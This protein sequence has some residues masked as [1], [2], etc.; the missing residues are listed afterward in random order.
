M[1]IKR[2]SFVTVSD[3]IS[4]LRSYV[5]AVSIPSN[6]ELALQMKELNNK[7][8]FK[9]ALSLFNM[10]KQCEMNDLA[11]NQALQACV[12]LRDFR[13]GSSIYKQLSSR[14]L[15][16]RH[17]QTS[18]VQLV[19]EWLYSFWKKMREI[20]LFSTV[21]RCETCLTYIFISSTETTN[22]IPVHCYNHWYWF[23]FSHLEIQM[24]VCLIDVWIGFIWND[25]NESW[26]SSPMNSSWQLFSMFVL[27]YQM[28]DQLD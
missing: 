9:S 4:T 7:K 24:I 5:R 28:I 2:K 8:D 6:V 3:L 25:R 17:I 1:M 10:Y 19:S 18:L 26:P 11:I 27:L 13:R 12:D 21:W 14:S 22:T 23:L 16:W 20:W 15:K